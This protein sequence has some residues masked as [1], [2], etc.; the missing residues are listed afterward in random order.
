MIS[1]NGYTCHSI[2]QL[3]HSL[4]PLL[5]QRSEVSRLSF[6]YVMYVCTYAGLLEP[7]TNQP[8]SA[9][10][11]TEITSP[12]TPYALRTRSQFFLMHSHATL[13]RVA[14]KTPVENSTFAYVRS[15]VCIYI[16]LSYLPC[17]VLPCPALE[18]LEGKRERPEQMRA[19]DCSLFTFTQLLLIY[20]CTCT[21]IH[22]Y[23]GYWNKS[24]NST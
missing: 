10:E 14:A 23:N 22:A 5:P 1:F 19:R 20:H 12:R 7:K 18:A 13:G 6:G 8:T 16:S 21:Y 4:S 9:P 15:Y 11:H 3:Q 2:T 24:V 17:P